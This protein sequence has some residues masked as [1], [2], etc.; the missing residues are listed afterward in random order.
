MYARDNKHIGD[1][2]QESSAREPTTAAFTFEDAL[3]DCYP[4]YRSKRDATQT[5]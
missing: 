2:P 5:K 4:G 3:A 1:N